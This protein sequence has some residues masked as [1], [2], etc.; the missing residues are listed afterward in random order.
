MNRYTDYENTLTQMDITWMDQFIPFIPL[1]TK[2]NYIAEIKIL[3]FVVNICNNFYIFL[4]QVIQNK[5]WW[6][7]DSSGLA[8]VMVTKWFRGGILLRSPS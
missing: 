2:V 8:C 3:L 6:Q 7:L 1:D 4:R 5:K